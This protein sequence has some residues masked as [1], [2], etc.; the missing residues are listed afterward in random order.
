MIAFLQGTLLEIW[1]KSCLILTSGGAG[2]E[3]ALPNH[4]FLQLPQKGEQVSFFTSLIVREDALEL[5]GF[6][7]FEERQTF[8]VLTGISRVGA[9]TALA[10]L[11]TFRPHELRQAVAENNSS[12]L[13]RVSGIGQKTAQ[14]IFL[15]LKYKLSSPGINTGMT[16]NAVSASSIFNDVLAALLNLG[17]AE[18][19]CVPGIRKILSKEPDLDLGSAIRITLKTLAKGKP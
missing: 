3:I 17:Y 12:A 7:T 2:Y 13:T 10:I 1:N 19:E 5:F 9:R 15:E 4:T 18:D 11:S 6:D 14:H 8:I 16:V